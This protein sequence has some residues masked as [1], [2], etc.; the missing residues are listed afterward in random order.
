MVKILMMSGKLATP[1]LLKI[2]TSKQ[3]LCHHNCWLWCHQQN[4]ITWHQS[5]VTLAFL[6]DKLSQPQFYKNL[7]GKILFFFEGWPWFKFN[8]LRLTLDMTLKFYTSVAKG[9]KLK[10]RQFLGIS[11]AFVKVAGD[12]LVGGGALC[13]P[14]PPILNRAK[15]KKNLPN[16]CDKLV[17]P[18]SRAIL[19]IYFY[20]YHMIK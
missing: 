18:T 3:R 10:V 13:C 2:D 5:L 7:T 6:W 16:E 15:T 20:G 17:L 1:G 4:S 14:P 8:N 11:P 19:I 12:K 9:L